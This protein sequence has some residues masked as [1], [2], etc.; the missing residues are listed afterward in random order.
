[1]RLTR[2]AVVIAAGAGCLA[3]LTSGCGSDHPGS[4][5]GGST[6]GTNTGSG[7][8]SAGGLYL[9]DMGG[10]VGSTTGGTGADA[11][12]DE[13]AGDLVEAK[14]IPL[15][16][17]VML[18]QSGSM[19]SATDS[20]RQ[21]S[22][23]DAVSS[24]LIDFV[25]DPESA[26]LGVGLQLF[27][28]QHPQ[29]PAQCTT[30]QQCGDFGPCLVKMCWPWISDAIDQCDSNLKCRAVNPVSNCVT[31][32]VCANDKGYVC[33]TFGEACGPQDPNDPL[34]RDLGDCVTNVPT[35]MNPADCR[36]DTYATPAAPI[37]ELPG[38]SAALVSV[39][40]A[41]V[42]DGLTPTEPALKGAIQAASAYATANPEH[43]VI[44]VLATDG[45]PSHRDG[46][47]SA[48]ACDAITQESAQQDLD[49]LFEVASSGQAA[50]PSIATFVIGV[51]GRDDQVGPLILDLIA[52][53]GG[54]E[55]AFI[56]DTAGDVGAQF[57]A[58][59]NQI[60]SG[61]LSCELL[62]PEPAVGKKLD[63]NEVNVVYDNGK[64]PETLVRYAARA[65]C[66][67]N[68]GWYYDV[69]PAAG[70]PTRIVACPTTCRAFEQGAGGSV[71]I[72]LGCRTRVPVK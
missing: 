39:I 49:A 70:I 51:L 20:N 21:L 40:E 1:M 61:R 69:D 32:G 72:K 9:G 62:V 24:A 23:W 18:D 66:Q 31:I 60:R 35:C 19:L 16:M 55:Q 56:V 27:P 47:G 58:A 11:P 2:A 68:A 3:L 54:T 67:A 33:P 38:G 13:C 46:P 59:L 45:Q 8:A 64:G 36:S 5:V 29:A 26:G 50:I 71:S 41:A 10:S 22:K 7:N 6:G 48:L 4:A 30:N 42:P 57:R 28:R 14:P 12:I 53:A 17:Y 43:Q 25:N 34:S 63:F 65:D 15:D 37:V 52:Q 44:A